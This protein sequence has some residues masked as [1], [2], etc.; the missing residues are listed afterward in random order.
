VAGGI[1]VHSDDWREEEKTIG[2][3]L[4]TNAAAEANKTGRKERGKLSVLQ[5]SKIK[6][7]YLAPLKLSPEGGYPHVLT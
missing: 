6:A 7:R 3:Q 5:I 2:S 4:E 1:S